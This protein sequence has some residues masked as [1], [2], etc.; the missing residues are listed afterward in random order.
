MFRSDIASGVLPA[1]RYSPNNN[2]IYSN[3]TVYIIIR[4]P[5]PATARSASV[6][7]KKKKRRKG[8]VEEERKKVSRRRDQNLIPQ[9]GQLI[10]SQGMKNIGEKETGSGPPAHLPWTI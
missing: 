5:T 2:N 4:E 10:R 7:A 8:M 3:F 6:N 9:P 1:A